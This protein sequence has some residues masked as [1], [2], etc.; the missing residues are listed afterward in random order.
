MLTFVLPHFL[1]KSLTNLFKLESSNG[2]MFD[3]DFIFETMK[4]KVGIR[5]F[6]ISHDH[7]CAHLMHSFIHVLLFS[8][9]LFFN[10]LKLLF[11][12]FQLYKTTVPFLVCIQEIL[13]FI[14]FFSRGREKE[15][16]GRENMY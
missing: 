14:G 9:S 8:F 6:C 2:I 7:I 15:R 10:F 13:S 16:G 12:R 3:R 4:K 11:T 1:Y 5:G